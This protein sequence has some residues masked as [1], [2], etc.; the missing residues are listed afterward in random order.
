MTKIKPRDFNLIDLNSINTV[1]KKGKD[2]DG[3]IYYY[4]NIP[5]NL[6]DLFPIF[7]NSKNNEYTVEKIYGIPAITLYLDELLTETI[8]INIMNSIKR[9]QN[10]SIPVND[11][12]IDIYS[13]YSNKIKKRYQNYDYSKFKNSNNLYQS[14]IK[15]IE[16]YQTKKL[17]HLRIIHG[18]P[19]LSNIIINE[20][21]KIK[22]IDMR[23]KIGN[24][25]SLC[26]DWL[27]DWA[28]LYQS[29]IGYDEILENKVLNKIIRT[30]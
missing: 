30:T 29:L 21:N 28:K 25:L 3:E 12:D 19:V 15:E 10:E 18:D 13:N 11:I 7:I 4:K 22:F 5:K 27:Y 8:L 16:E 1:T 26:G 17:G 20:H 9:I 14:L 2:L 6:K 24:K 23:G